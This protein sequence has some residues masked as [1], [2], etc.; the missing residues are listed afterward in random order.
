[1]TSGWLSCP[2]VTSQ[3]TGSSAKVS[4]GVSYHSSEGVV[5]EYKLEIPGSPQTIHAQ[6]TCV[7][8]L[9]L[10]TQCSPYSTSG[11]LWVLPSQNGIHTVHGKANKTQSCVTPSNL[12]STGGQ[13]N[14]HPIAHLHLSPSLFMDP[15]PMGSPSAEH[16]QEG[17]GRSRWTPPLPVQRQGDL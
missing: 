6:S 12:H 9:V 10:E 5:V 17:T 13:G 16:G 7:C 11:Y 3:H 8:T 15:I 2:F 14:K 1:M 4:L